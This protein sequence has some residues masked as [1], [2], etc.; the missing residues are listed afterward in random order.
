VCA[1]VGKEGA[2]T[3]QHRTITKEKSVVQG[4]CSG[5]SLEMH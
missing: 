4:W 2:E 1:S 3:L 5:D